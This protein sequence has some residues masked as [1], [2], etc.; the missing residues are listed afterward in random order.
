MSDVLQNTT[1]LVT[2]ASSGIGAA[3]AIRL[4]S[5]GATVALVARR[6]GRL[7]DVA[8]T[9]EAACGRAVIIEADISDQAAALAALDEAADRMGR[10]DIL[11][12]NA[13][14]M[15]L[16]SALHAS[17]EERD[18][19]LSV[20]V[21]GVLAVTHAASPTWCGRLRTH[22]ERSLTSSRSAQPLDAWH[23]REAASTT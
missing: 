21:S 20:N 7:A 1:A 10:L 3:T 14:T 11:V 18:R 2:G 23:D 8:S 16:V 19:M 17:V 15:L 9:I 22:R 4:A 6:R 13:G 5:E 12:D